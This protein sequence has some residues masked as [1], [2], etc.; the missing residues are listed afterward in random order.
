MPHHI[1]ILTSAFSPTPSSPLC[2]PHTSK[3]RCTLK[4]TFRT[5]YP[6]IPDD[7]FPFLN[8]ILYRK[9]SLNHVL[10]SAIYTLLNCKPILHAPTLFINKLR[11]IYINN[12]L[13]S[14]KKKVLC[15]NSYSMG[16]SIL[17]L[18]V[19]SVRLYPQT[20][21]TTKRPVMLV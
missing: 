10:S 3:L 2:Y 5:Q 18:K 12:S 9:V 4:L 20:N 11:Q 21:D 14:V 15:Q 1:H 6:W 17:L 8:S 16:I 19:T 13:K 7:Q